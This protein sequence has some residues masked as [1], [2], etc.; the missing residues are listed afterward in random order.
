MRRTLTLVVALVALLAIVAA[1]AWVVRI[2]LAQA[3]LEGTL[4]ARGYAEARFEITAV[5]LERIVVEDFELRDARNTRV[6]RLSA[7]YTPWALLTGSWSAVAVD[8]TGLR[9]EVAPRRGSSPSEPSARSGGSLGDALALAMRLERLRLSAAQI[10][11]ASPVG[12]WRVEAEGEIRAGE[13]APRGELRLQ[14]RSERLRVDATVD[15]ELADGRLSVDIDAREDD[16]FRIRGQASARAPW[17]ESPMRVTARVAMPSRADLPWVLLPGPR[18][19]GG[20]LHVA[21]QAQGRLALHDGIDGPGGLV[22]RLIAGDWS[23]NWRVRGRDLDFAYR[24]SGMDL[25]GRGQ[26]ASRDGALI[27]S[28]DEAPRL[29]LA[30]IH[31]ALRASLG[32]PAFARNHA[33]GPVELDWASGELA[34][35]A[36]VD[37]AAHSIRI[38]SEPDWHVHWPDTRGE[39]H[40]DARVIA[41]GGGRTGIDRLAVDDLDVRAADWRAPG[42]RLTRA[43]VTGDIEGLP[44]APSGRLEFNAAA[45]QLAL[46]GLELQG[47]GAEASARLEGGDGPT[48]LTLDDGPGTITVARWRAGNLVRSDDDLRLALTDAE[49]RLSRPR[50]WGA[51]MRVAPF[52]M[53]VDVGNRSE[54]VRVEPGPLRA[55]AHAGVLQLAVVD[56][57]GRIVGRDWVARGVDVTLRPR[58]RA[59]FAAFD[60]DRLAHAAERPWLAPATMA[61]RIA[62][63]AGG[64][65]LT[66]GGRVPRAELRFEFDGDYASAPGAASAV[67]EVPRMRWRPDGRQPQDLLPRLDRLGEVTGAASARVEGRLDRRGVRTEA[68]IRVDDVAMQVAGVRLHGVSGETRLSGLRPLKTQR[69]QQMRIG[70]VATAVPV[71]DIGLQWRIARSRGAGLGV[72]IIQAEG[73]LL[74]GRA[75]VEDARI[76]TGARLNELDLELLD[77]S[78]G[79]LVDGSGVNGLGARGKLSGRVPLSFGEP[80]VAVRGARLRGRDGHIALRSRA[81]SKALRQGGRDAELML[82]AL[83]DFAYDTLEIDVDAPLGGRGRIDFRLE[84]RNPEV[85]GGESL[86]YEIALTGA[87]APLLEAVARGEPLSDARIARHLDLRAAE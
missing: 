45:P 7:R 81:A 27:V 73:D 9:A 46:A 84:G 39:L 87:V 38:T 15:A 62:R 37:G 8:V 53:D 79:G 26:F 36:P 12:P 24:F 51:A 1:G 85:L 74:E 41:A 76:D 28:S 61:G 14:G 69:A 4:A 25:Q 68:T 59:D 65:D 16:G 77:V 6:R 18:P 3:W 43:R 34:R 10:Q 44:A 32:V 42:I 40:L 54:R 29:R 64:Y 55:G 11:L 47:V 71:T 75:R 17:D 2:H 82:S 78:L 58:A 23:G 72:R 70:R 66:G 30:R 31:D 63:N 13:A 83:R 50:H 5:D 49:W 56:G 80:G 33:D 35:I 60:V 19:S 67:L 22:E 48:R 86:D 52:E 21:G 57:A 20:A